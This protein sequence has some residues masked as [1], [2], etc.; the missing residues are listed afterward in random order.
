MHWV[1]VLADRVHGPGKRHSFL[2]KEELENVLANNN[3]SESSAPWLR[4][5]RIFNALRKP[6]PGGGGGTMPFL[7]G[8]NTFVTLTE[9][10]YRRMERWA[11]GECEADWPGQEPVAP[12]LD[13]LPVQDRPHALDRA[14]LDA[15]VGAGL[16]PGIEAGRIM[17]DPDTYQ[18][19]F[20]ISSK[21]DGG[22]REAG[23]LT[24]RMSVPWQADFFACDFERL[25]VTGGRLNVRI[26]SYAVRSLT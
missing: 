6:G 19:P 12:S 3:K 11:K 26:K 15:C 5:N 22:Q 13:E 16:F 14:A 10:Q 7:S 4:R 24:A 8:G 18:R 20:R 9:V 23:D 17:R 25:R 1:T 21:R 2:D